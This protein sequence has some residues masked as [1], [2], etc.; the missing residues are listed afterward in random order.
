[1]NS[2]KPDTYNRAETFRCDSFENNDYRIDIHQGCVKIGE[3]SGLSYSVTREMAPIYI[4]PESAKELRRGKKGIA[5]TIIFKELCKEEVL[6][7][8][9]Q[10]R[11]R[12]YSNSMCI[13]NA[14]LI[15]E[16]QDINLKDVQLEE[17]YTFVA[18]DIIGWLE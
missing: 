7:N 15:S 3:A 18:Q 6:G 9:F 16:K 10:L 14:E 11:I 1:M 2:N 12:A 4:T 8:K 5:G 17:Q 13:I